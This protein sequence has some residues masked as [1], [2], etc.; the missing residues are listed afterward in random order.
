[1]NKLWT[2]TPSGQLQMNDEEVTFVQSIKAFRRIYDMFTEDVDRAKHFLYIWHM[3]DYRSPGIVNG[4]KDKELHV[5][6]ATQAGL[7]ATFV[8]PDFIKHA[9][10]VYK[11]LEEDV[12]EEQ[13]KYV[14]I[15]HHNSARMLAVI[16]N[17]IETLLQKAEKDGRL[18][19][20]QEDDLMDKQ[21]KVTKIAADLSKHAKTIAELEATLAEHRSKQKKLRGQSEYKVSMDNDLA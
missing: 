3:A 8:A 1:M 10:E 21:A 5:F 16:S 11:E 19:T 7:R 4:L 20:T 17:S 15:V 13:F 14:K 6:A 9:V 18:S 12:I 2:V